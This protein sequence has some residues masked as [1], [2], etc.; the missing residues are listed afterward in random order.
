MRRSFNEWLETRSYGDIKGAFG[1][2]GAGIAAGARD[3]VAE[4]VKRI[5]ADP[6]KKEWVMKG[7]GPDMR[8]AV[9]DALAAAEEIPET[10][11]AIPIKR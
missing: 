10:P 7:I 11:W 6:S 1:D 4:Y 3:K 5:K 2:M 9:E 8:Q